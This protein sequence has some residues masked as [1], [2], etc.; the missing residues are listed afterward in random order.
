MIKL[1]APTIEFGPIVIPGSRTALYPMK[2]IIFYPNPAKAQ[3]SLALVLLTKTS[4]ASVMCY[5][6]N[7]ITYRYMISDADQIRL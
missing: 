7:L 3:N 1:H 4:C 5:K 6:S 2:A